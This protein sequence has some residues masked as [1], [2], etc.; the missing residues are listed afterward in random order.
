[1]LKPFCKDR[2]SS[3][4]TLMSMICIQYSVVL[5]LFFHKHQTAVGRLGQHETTQA[6]LIALTRSTN[7]QFASWANENG[8]YRTVQIN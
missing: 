4:L 5:V 8:H 7:L 6:M 1:M 3:I 2:A